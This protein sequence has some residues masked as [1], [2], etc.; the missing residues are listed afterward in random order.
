LGGEGGCYT[1]LKSKI[2]GMD[3]KRDA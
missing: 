3:M 2:Q 1:C